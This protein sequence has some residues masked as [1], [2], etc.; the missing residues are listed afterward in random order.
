LLSNFSLKEASYSGGG[1]ITFK[2]SLEEQTYYE[3]K[4][5]QGE[6]LLNDLPIHFI[7]SVSYIFFIIIAEKTAHINM[8]FLVLRM[9]SYLEYLPMHESY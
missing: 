1:N 3:S 9:P 8:F 5:F 7:Y 2:G 6:F 4:I